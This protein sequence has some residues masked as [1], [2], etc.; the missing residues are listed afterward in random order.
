MGGMFNVRALAANLQPSP[1][2][3]A[4]CT[5]T[6]PTALSPPGTH[7]ALLHVPSLRLGRTRTSSTSR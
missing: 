6:A 1:S 3:D 5:S 7:L 2:L 4:A